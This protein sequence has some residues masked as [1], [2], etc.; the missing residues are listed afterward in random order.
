MIRG[1]LANPAFRAQFSGHET[2]PLRHLWLKKAYDQVAAAKGGV[3][4]K[5][6]FNDAEAIVTFGVGKNMV[7]AIRHWALTCGILKED[8]DVFRTTNIGDY[9][10]SDETGVDPFLEAPATL[11]LLHWMMAG[12]PERCTTWFYVFNHL[13][14]QTFDHDAIAAPLRDYRDQQ[15]ARLKNKIRASDATIKRD[16]E[17][18]LRS[19]VPTRQGKFSDDLFEPA[20]VPLGLIRAVSSK[21]YQFRRGAKPTLPDGVFLY[22]LHEFWMRHAPDQQTLSVEAL[23]FEPGSPGRVFKL[24]EDALVERLA[25]IEES[26]ARAYLWSDTAGVRNVARRSL[27]PDPMMFLASAY[28]TAKQRSAA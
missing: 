27:N 17:C 4:P 19:Y 18:F 14:V 28:E 25:R 22:A 7:G 9:L 20:L 5:S 26:T 23:T 10:F 13:T 8:G 21:S 12:T 15:N 24:D 6:L 16:V 2:F 3:A 11:W 1:P